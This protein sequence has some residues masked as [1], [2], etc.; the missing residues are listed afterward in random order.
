LNALESYKNTEE[1][2]LEPVLVD[3]SE[4]QADDELALTDDE[5]VQAD[6]ELV[7]ADDELVQAD[8]ELVQADDEL[9]LTD[10]ELVQADDELA[11]TDD[12]LALTDDE[13]E[14]ADDQG[15]ETLPRNTKDEDEQTA[16]VDETDSAVSGNTEKDS[17]GVDIKP[18]FENDE[19]IYGEFV[20]GDD[21]QVF[22][23][24][25]DIDSLPSD[26]DL[27]RQAAAELAVADE[28]SYADVPETVSS[29][30]VAMSDEEVTLDD[31]VAE[32]VAA[33][34]AAAQE[35]SAAAKETQASP[36][37]IKLTPPVRLV[38]AASS[39]SSG[40]KAGSEGQNSGVMTRS[41]RNLE[42]S[43]VDFKD[44]F[45]MVLQFEG[46]ARVNVDLS[47]LTSESKKIQMAG[48]VINIFQVA[49]G[50]T[51]EIDGVEMFFPKAIGLVG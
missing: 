26:A 43:G 6:D 37:P 34:E 33:H 44:D 8:D 28:S 2:K 17:S 20:E 10:D 15:S 1:D 3:G 48:K 36:A 41:S 19:L 39:G 35:V 13:L 50:Y 18:E 23:D 14:L 16:L 46:G 45:T 7:Q 9:A 5:L 49:D 29:G 47:K 38:D 32:P 11:L 51:I 30:S 42:F 12:E 31:E 4:M 25:I 24:G 40:A 27:R 21:E 22:E